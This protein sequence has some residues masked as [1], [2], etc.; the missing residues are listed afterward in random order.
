M[1]NKNK[2]FNYENK[3]YLELLNSINKEF[4]QKYIFFIK[5]YMGEKSSFFLDVGCGNGNAL[6]ELIKEGYKNI[7]GCDI[8][9]LFLKT[10]KKRGLK[11]LF[12]YD[13][14]SLPFS[15]DSF[16]VVG[17]FTVLEHV[18]NPEAFLLEQV[19]VTKKSGIIIVAC[20]NFLSPFFPFSHPRFNKFS[21]RIINIPKIID[22]LTSKDCDFEKVEPIVRKNFQADD[23]M[24]VITNLIDVEK[25][26][27]QNKC[28]IIF[29]SGLLNKNNFLIRFIELIPTFKYLFPS[30]FLIAEKN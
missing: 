15:S 18:N 17:S 10:A 16:D 25:F 12:F 3:K 23:D 6:V 29:S 8:S 1:D 9:L 7:F 11:N 2:N 30:C 24:I 14:N 28:K 21:K 4:Y 5:K 22:K 13:G 19:R 27:K 20:P 26:F